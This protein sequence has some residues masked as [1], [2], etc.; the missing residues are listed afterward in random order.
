MEN[1]VLKQVRLKYP[2]IYAAAQKAAFWLGKELKLN[3]PPSEVGY[4]AMHFGAAV[5]RMKQE[6]VRAKRILFVCASGLG[7]AKLLESTLRRELPGV[8]WVD[9]VAVSR[10]KEKASSTHVDLIISTID[11]NDEQL[12]VPVITISPLPNTKELNQLKE[13]LYLASDYEPVSAQTPSV[14]ALMN[15]IKRYADVYDKKGLSLALEKWLGRNVNAPKQSGLDRRKETSPMLDQLLHEEN[16]RVQAQCKDWQ[17]V[18]ETGAG[19]LLAK[20]CI[21]SEYVSQIKHYLEEHGPYMV[22]APGVVLLHARPE[23]GVNDVCMSLM[24]LKQP[25]E[26]GHAQNDPVDVVITFA[27]LDS[28]M[29]V[30]ALSQM[31]QLLSDEHSLKKLREAKEEKEVLGIIQPFVREGGETR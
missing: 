16:I 25:V 8:E 1:P 7:T 29:H 26:F 4:L 18:V 31:M 24:T 2:Q 14:S 13:R 5:T 15:V 6:S 3:I 28:E 10:V 22:I 21:E 9:T 23:D 30:Q 19:I 11:L 27:T 17:D 20:G 12:D